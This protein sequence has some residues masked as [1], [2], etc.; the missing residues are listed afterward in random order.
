MNIDSASSAALAVHAHK[1]VYAVL[2]GSGVSKAAGI[3]TGWDIV[4]DLI[5]RV[6]RLEN[7]DAGTEPEKWYHE[8][9]KKQPNYSELVQELAPMPAE[10]MSLLKNYFE[11]TEQEKEQGSKVPTAAH[12]AIAKLVASG[13]IKVIV[14]TNFD[15]LMERALE[16]EGVS[17]AVVSSPDQVAGMMPLQ[18]AQCVVIKMHGDYLD[19][20]IRNTPE[21]LASYD[22]ET[23]ALLDRVFSEYGLIVCGWSVDWDPALAAAVV[24]NT[25]YRFSTYWMAYG[26]QS[27]RAGDLIKHRQAAVIGIESADRA[28][29]DLEAKVE[30]L[31]AQRVGDPMSPRLAISMMKRFLSEE[32]YRIQLEDL[33]VGELNA[34][35]KRTGLDAFP[36]DRPTPDETTYPARV[37][38]MEMTCSKLVPIVAAGVYWG[39]AEVDNLWRRCVETLL[40]TETRSGTSYNAWSYLLY[41]PATLILYAAGIASILRKQFDLLKSLLVDAQ[42]V[43]G[44]DDPLPAVARIG[45]ELC[46]HDR[47][48]QLLH[49]REKDT[50]LKTPGSDW[51]VKRLQPM[52]VDVIGGD[53]SFEDLFDELE[54]LIVLV[55]IDMDL[56]GWMG[57]FGWRSGKLMSRLSGEI[58]AQG[59]KHPLLR[60]GFFGGQVE[61]FVKAWE[62][63]TET[64][65]R[66]RFPV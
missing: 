23:N 10:R 63:L 62:L 53:V 8:R 60:V 22:N 55:A 45:S 65:C 25:R 42:A 13:Y 34:V 36:V 26:K 28:F 39:K 31:A 1:G 15:R 20:R 35:K 16:A 38:Q 52:L 40:R 37:E 2:L 4:I 48:A 5:H 47:A 51:M 3:P 30:A 41:Y 49:E 11:P 58:L 32:K 61:R 56:P 9:F 27:D 29:A 46:F 43:C 17:P 21:E 59:V 24:R 54:I 18:H 6:A 64:R 7:G 66:M 50:T 33:V 57:R 14:T 44:R 19:T 12:R